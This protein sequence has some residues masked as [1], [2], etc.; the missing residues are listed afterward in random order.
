MAVLPVAKDVVLTFQ[1]L[2]NEI[3]REQNTLLQCIRYIVK[4]KS[5]GAG[6]GERLGPGHG[7][8]E[9]QTDGR[10]AAGSSGEVPLSSHQTT[11]LLP[12]R[13]M[14]TTTATTISPSD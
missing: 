5:L 7:K 10:E 2:A 1:L 3:R 6:G 9:Q 4:T 14:A 13:A 8:R 11:T 12:G